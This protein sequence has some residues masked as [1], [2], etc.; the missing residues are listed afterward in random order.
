[1]VTNLFLDSDT[2][3]QDQPPGYKESHKHTTELSND[4]T[5]GHKEGGIIQLEQIQHMT[6]KTEEKPF[7][8]KQCGAGFPKSCGLKQHMRTHTGEKPFICKECGAA[9]LKNCNLKQHMLT[10]TGEKPFICNQCGSR[11]YKGSDM[12]KH[13]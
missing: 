8:C 13:M 10:H 4:V 5:E 12:K 3:D 6:M 9:F 7:I 2:A 1:M 11:F